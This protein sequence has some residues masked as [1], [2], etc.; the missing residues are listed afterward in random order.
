LSLTPGRRLG[1]FEIVAALGAGG[2]GEVYRARDTKLGREVAVKILPPSFVQDPE[3]V[4]RFHREAQLLAALNHPHI[5]AIHGLEDHDGT[6]LLVME[7]VDGETLADRLR[8]SGSG[9][10]TSGSGRVQG[11]P[12]GSP[13]PDARRLSIDEA[14]GIARQI[15]DALEAA[16]E[17]GII[18]RDLKPANVALTADGH[19]KVL[20]FGLAKFTAGGP[21]DAEPGSGGLSHSPTLTVAATQAGVI[22]GTAAYMA[23]E[24]AKGKLADKRADIW[25]FGCV[26]YEMLTGRR[27]FDGEDL[28]DT[29]AAVV[30]GEPD[31]SAIPSDVPDQIRL[32]VRRCLEK[33]RR[34]RI[35]D[36]SV[37]RF[38]LTETIAPPRPDPPPPATAPV[39]SRR[40]AAAAAAAGL[41]GGAVL[42]AGAWWAM[43]GPPADRQ[44]IR[45]ALIP[46]PD[47]P[48][49]MQGSDNDV[50]VAGDGT[51][52]VY[53]S[54]LGADA[55][56]MV[57]RRLDE[58]EARPL[59]A[60]LNTRSP[61][62]S[63]DDAWVGFF[64]PGALR[65]VP[66]GG[67]PP[68][69]IA[70]INGNARG[71]SW[72]ANDLIVFATTAPESGLWSVPG[73]G[74]DPKPLTTP[75]RAAGEGDHL[76]P[77]WLPDRRAVLFTIS[78]PTG[79]AQ[80]ADAFRIGVL[81]LDSGEKKILIQAGT[82]ARYVASGHILY[83]A[84]E[85]ALRAV[86][87]DPRRLEVIGDPMPV[88]D[89]VRGFSSGAV[90]FSASSTGVLVYVP[91]AGLR[92]AAERPLVWVNRQGE[93]TPLAAPG[94]G[95]ADPRMSPDGLQMIAEVPDDTD[96]IWMLDVARG[97]LSRQTVE[98]FEDETPV[99]SPDGRWIAYSST[100]GNNDRLVFRLRSDGAGAEETLWK[101]T[102]H[103]HVEDWTPDGKSLVVSSTQTAGSPQDLFLLPLD[104]DRALKPLLRTRFSERA[105]RVSPD[106]R[107]MAYCSDETGR[108]EVYVRPFPSL[109]GRYPISSG[110]GCQPVWSR[111]T[112]ELFYRGGGAL[113]T[114]PIAPGDRFTAGSPQKLFDDPFYNKGAGHTGYDVTA[115][116]RFLFV[117]N[118]IETATGSA[119]PIHLVI[120]WLQAPR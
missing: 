75:D 52:L 87:F 35:S 39:P 13:E 53:R 24:Q 106:G 105:A 114:V 108:D 93:R 45:M 40:G 23:P 19:V 11:S 86:R 63:P 100:R 1:A 69:T 92:G 70:S 30:R 16:H 85:G 41:L 27:A 104:G 38:L 107:W 99:W 79:L 6:P 20:D 31:W 89:D 73:S 50:A 12:S 9:L 90:E 66:A 10:R 65:K 102:E 47:Q 91:G 78:P 15:A 36:I 59:T 58:F 42:A 113:M 111:K 22:L 81:D 33:D 71:A 88:V 37:V 74:G 5:A 43:P 116:G 96:D 60:G 57:I 25:A 29:I 14:L 98:S 112:A 103:I 76:Y 84:G 55:S 8:P 82:Y 67:G 95:Y 61:F 4:A 34:A 101:G 110:G 3:R 2:M 46:A 64:A 7:L 118:E 54:T 28:T 115:D 72:G 109:E 120:N 117:A 18:H 32:L 44:T 51:F 48:L 97:T 17:K 62:V 49:S 68:V 94:R 26:L 21:G 83:A 80:T 56:Q 119:L 77:S